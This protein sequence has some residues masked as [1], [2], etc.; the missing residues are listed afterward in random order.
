MVSWLFGCLV[1]ELDS[2]PP[3][4]L[5]VDFMGKILNGYFWLG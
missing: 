4:S 1:K 3:L 2:R 5:S